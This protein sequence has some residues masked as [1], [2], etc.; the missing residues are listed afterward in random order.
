MFLR[1]YGYS[2]RQGLKGFIVIISFNLVI[3]LSLVIIIWL[4]HR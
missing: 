4:S 1:H 3:A 2:L